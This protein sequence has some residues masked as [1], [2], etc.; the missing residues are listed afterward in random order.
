[1]WVLNLVRGR[2]PEAR[3]QKARAPCHFPDTGSRDASPCEVWGGAAWG[4]LTLMSSRLTGHH[5]RGTRGSQGPHW[6]RGSSRKIS[7]GT[8]AWTLS[9]Q[10]NQP[11]SFEQVGQNPGKEL[12]CQLGLNWLSEATVE[13]GPEGGT[14]HQ[15]EDVGGVEHSSRARLAP[16]SSPQISCQSLLPSWQVFP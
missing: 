1:M 7:H 13:L 6:G 5:R 15:A 2:W 12:R 4:G 14:G 11:G 16:D 9:T 8:E 10:R 3:T